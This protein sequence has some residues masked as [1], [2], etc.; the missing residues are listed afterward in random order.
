MLSFSTGF[1]RA[2]PII[3]GLDFTTG[4]GGRFPKKLGTVLETGSGLAS[5]EKDGP[6]EVIAKAGFKFTRI[7]FFTL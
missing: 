5:A 7:R 2:E 3:I 4:F 6:V 1:N